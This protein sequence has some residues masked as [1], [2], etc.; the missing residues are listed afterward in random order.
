LVG[1]SE[2]NRPHGKPIYIG[3]NNNKMDLKKTGYEGAA[4]ILLA[5]DRVHIAGC[6]E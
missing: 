1:K 6:G 2:E 5:W 4:W 3:K